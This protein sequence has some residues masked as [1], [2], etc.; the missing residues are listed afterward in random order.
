MIYTVTLNPTLDITYVIEEVTFG[1]PVSALEVMKT[2][3]GKGV[4]VSRALRAMGTDSVAMALLGGHAGDEVLDLLH[5]EG[6]ILQIVK[7]KSETR[8]NVVV[9]GE[10]DGRELVIRAAGPP[11]DVEEAE[12][13]TRL[14]FQLAEA[15]EVLVISGSLPPGLEPSIYGSLVR[16][17][18]SRGSRVVLDSKG[19]PLASGVEAGPFMIKPNLLE[20]EGLAGRAL[21]SEAEILGFARELNDHGVEV[22]VVSLGRE[23]ALLVTRDDALRGRVPAVSEDTVG[24]GD[25]MVAG[26]VMGLSQ[27]RPLGEVFRTG[28]ACAVSAVMNEGPGLVDEKTFAQALPLVRIERIT[29]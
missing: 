4:N 11:V 7:I 25:S 10:R 17:G 14:L 20:F 22:V 23:G 3:G 21:K 2:P 6:L 19:P 28:L 16:E 1:E 9:L 26:M 8:T 27:S 15:P 13:I 24:A 12:M 29:A 5:H 18:K